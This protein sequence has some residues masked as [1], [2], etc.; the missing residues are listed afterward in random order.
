[1]IVTIFRSRL[2]PGVQE[3]YGPMAKRMSELARGISGYVSHK[4]F[5]AEDG[6][7]VTIVEFETEAALK[8][9]RVEPEHAK[10]KKRGIESFFSDY[11][12]Q[13]CS[14]IRG[15]AWSSTKTVEAK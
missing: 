5:V 9:W 11:S 1:M 8:A 12:F 14:V 7:R 13:I 3:D 10:A 2:N 4:G 15:R 6:E